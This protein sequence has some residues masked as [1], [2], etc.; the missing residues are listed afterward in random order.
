MRAE[1][2][3]E[4]GQA[5]VEFA[6]ILPMLLLLIVGL[7]Q[8]GKAFNYWLSLNHIANETARWAA[9]DRLPP[10]GGGDAW[11]TSPSVDQLQSYAAN[12]AQNQE[13]QERIVADDNPDDLSNVVV[14]YTPSAQGAAPQVG[15]A[16]TVQVRVPYQLP[17]VSSLSGLDITL[18]GTSTVR[19]EQVP[20]SGWEPCAG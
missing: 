9:V 3:A 19:L 11:I 13:L 8:F 17:V 14:C 16:A 5:T 10:S 18:S 2:R 4:Q 20:G 7:I 6:I 1:G 15:D 12:Q